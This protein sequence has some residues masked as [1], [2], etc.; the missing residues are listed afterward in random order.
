MS[1]YFDELIEYLK[2]LETDL[3][4]EINKIIKSEPS[5]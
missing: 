3:Q 1:R 4:T 2:R 5:N